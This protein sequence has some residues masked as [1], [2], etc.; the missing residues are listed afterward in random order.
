MSNR[1]FDLIYFLAFLLVVGG[2]ILAARMDDDGSESVAVLPDFSLP[3]IELEANFDL[4]YQFVRFVRPAAPKLV[5]STNVES[6]I[7]EVRT[8]LL[9]SSELVEVE[10]VPAGDLERPS[11]DAV[12]TQLVAVH[13]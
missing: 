4:P 3:S 12:D 6:A 8:A 7:V 11:P 5:L 13:D 1:R 2:G 9:E 10:P